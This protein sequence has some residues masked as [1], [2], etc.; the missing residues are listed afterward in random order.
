MRGA[1]LKWQLRPAI[2]V[3]CLQGAGASERGTAQS[4]GRRNDAR[5]CRLSLPIALPSLLLPVRVL[6]V[7]YTLNDR[8]HKRSRALLSG[9]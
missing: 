9:R 3:K 4:G 7:V 6:H 5:V 1:R 8:R 2:T